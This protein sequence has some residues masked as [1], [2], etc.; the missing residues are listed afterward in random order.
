MTLKHVCQSDQFVT[1]ARR[2]I[3]NKKIQRTP[4]KGSDQVVHK[5]VFVGITP[6]NGRVITLHHKRQ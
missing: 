3:D 6:D 4:V 2:H 1:C 5:V